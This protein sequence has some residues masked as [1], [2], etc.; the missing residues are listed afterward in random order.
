MTSSSLHYRCAQC[1]QVA[2][3]STDPCGNHPGPPACIFETPTA[4]AK[5]D[6]ASELLR[7]ASNVAIAVPALIPKSETSVP[8]SFCLALNSIPSPHAGPKSQ[9]PNPASTQTAPQSSTLTLQANPKPQ[10]PNP[11]PIPQ[12]TSSPTPAGLHEATVLGAARLPPKF[13]A[14]RREGYHQSGCLGFRL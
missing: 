1:S 6:V 2:A 13:R 11:I 3:V 14:P 10:I 8:L 9:P 4:S 5:Q 12:T 7:P